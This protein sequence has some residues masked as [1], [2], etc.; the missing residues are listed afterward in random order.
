MAKSRA[1]RN[2]VRRL[3]CGRFF[4]RCRVAG[5]F[6]YSAGCWRSPCPAAVVTVTSIYTQYTKY[7]VYINEKKEKR[8]GIYPTH[9]I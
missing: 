9:G 3:P 5:R 8:K 2:K 4:G 6:N 1:K 7:T